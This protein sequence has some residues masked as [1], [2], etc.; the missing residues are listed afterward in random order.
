MKSFFCIIQ[1]ELE[2]LYSSRSGILLLIIIPFVVYLILNSLYGKGNIHDLPVAVYDQDQSQLSRSIKRYL[3]ASSYLAVTRQL[4]S[5]DDLEE[6]L[7]AGEVQGIIVFPH[8]MEKR[9]MKS[10]SEKV[11]VYTNS[12]NIVFGNLIYKASSELVIAAA[13]EA[14]QK[15]LE[16]DGLSK[17]QSQELFEPIRISFKPLYHPSYNYLYYLTPGLML[18]LLQMFIMFVAARA[19]NLEFNSNTIKELAFGKKVSV[20]QIL[21]GK[22]L[23]HLFA[24]SILVLMIFGIFYSWFNIPLQASFWP[25][26]LLLFVFVSANIFIGFAF[27]AIFL[28]EMLALDFTLFYNSPAF[29][30]SGF[31]FPLMG[32]PWYSKMYAGL[33]PYTHFLYG[34]LKIEVM[35]A[36]LRFAANEIII[37]II[38]S[39]VGLITSFAFL[40]IRLNKW[41]QK[42][43]AQI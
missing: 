22:Y 6:V 41:T 24:A 40:S 34:F 31:T 16:K 30:F 36:P 18:V 35:E 20:F 27:S 43:E 11:M 28:D 5:E 13:S 23:A 4:T 2:R 12:S 32:M 19:I 39:L 8:Q 38:F 37:L 3:D 26:V 14:L 17:K 25:M 33:I 10:R 42:T 15:K 21:L 1:R 9:M 7:Q 29:V